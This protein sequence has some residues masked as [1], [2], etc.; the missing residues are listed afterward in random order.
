MASVG[1]C[2]SS[3]VKPT[4]ACLREAKCWDFAIL[5][6]GTVKMKMHCSWKTVISYPILTGA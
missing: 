3:E 2:A 5:G 4:L 1:V 6:L